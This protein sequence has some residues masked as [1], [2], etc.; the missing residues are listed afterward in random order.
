MFEPSIRHESDTLETYRS[1]DS[2]HETHIDTCELGRRLEC[3]SASGDDATE[4][5]ET[6]CTDDFC[7]HIAQKCG[8]DA[9]YQCLVG[10]SGLGCSDDP[11]GWMLAVD[12]TCSKCCD[13][14]SCA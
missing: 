6:A 4:S 5:C 2:I 14:R 1:Y 13:T 7:L 12:T 10:S 3:A 9:P 11:Y 8:D